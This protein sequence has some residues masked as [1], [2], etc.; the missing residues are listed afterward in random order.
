MRDRLLDSLLMHCGTKTYSF[1]KKSVWNW[2][3]LL[4]SW[5]WRITQNRKLVKDRFKESGILD[6]G[7]WRETLPFFFSLYSVPFLS[8]IVSFPVGKEASSLGISLQKTKRRTQWY[9]EAQITEVRLQELPEFVSTATWAGSSFLKTGSSVNFSPTR[10]F[11]VFASM[12]LWSAVLELLGAYLVDWVL[13]LLCVPELMIRRKFPGARQFSCCSGSPAVLPG[14]ETGCCL[15]VGSGQHT[16][17]EGHGKVLLPARIKA[18]PWQVERR[19]KWVLDQN[20][21]CNTTW[22]QVLNQSMAAGQGSAVSQSNKWN[23]KAQCYN[24]SFCWDFSPNYLQEVFHFLIFILNTSKKHK[25]M[26]IS[27]FSCSVT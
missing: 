10:K 24:E 9:S 17:K 7:R 26:I 18:C 12:T 20:S 21:K 1:S 25:H 14:A 11:S 3:V 13:M 19:N 4:K 23:V 15:P 22:R 16:L 5:S 2:A 8:V 6:K 27:F